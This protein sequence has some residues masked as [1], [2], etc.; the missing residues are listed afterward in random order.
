M[1]PVEREVQA[2]SFVYPCPECGAEPDKRCVIR[3]RTV[4]AP[5]YP[6]ARSFA[7]SR[8]YPH[9]E[10]VELAWRDWLAGHYGSQS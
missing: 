3:R 2:R 1:S 4:D 7:T 8:K 10:R 6:P 5:G 9:P